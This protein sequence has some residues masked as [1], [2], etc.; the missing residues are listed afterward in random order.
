MAPAEQPRRAFLGREIHA[1]FLH[2]VSAVDRG[3]ANQI[4]DAPSM[5]PFT[6]SPLMW[7]ES[8]NPWFRITAFAPRVADA[9]NRAASAWEGRQM[10]LAD[11]LYEVQAII[12][13][14]QRQPWASLG[15]YETLW[16]HYVRSWTQAARAVTLQFC[17]P[18][19]FRHGRE[20]CPLPDPALVFQSLLAK[21]NAFSP[22][23]IAPGLYDYI[24]TELS[25]GRYSLK[26]GLLDLGKQRRL[27]GF[28]GIC[29]FAARDRRDERFRLVQ[30]LAE[31]AFYSGVGHK[32]T[33][34]MGM[35]VP[36][37]P[38]RRAA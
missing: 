13:D 26:T 15:S 17:T 6:V 4:H 14:G 7:D 24:R 16:D 1:F 33:M 38:L 2:L 29:E 31:F 35:A 9:L 32:A 25:V 37:R 10:R 8:R 21:W 3:L 23:P 19:T 18:T 30:M 5:K 27:M 36:L 22:R 28:C 11:G 20:T 12:T 34:G